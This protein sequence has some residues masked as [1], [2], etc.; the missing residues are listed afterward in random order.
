MTD[1]GMKKASVCL[2][3]YIKKSIRHKHHCY[4]AYIRKES[5]IY[6]RCG[7]DITKVEECIEEWED[8]EE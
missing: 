8:G 2:N 4:C 6:C 1:E 5:P 3:E 7:K